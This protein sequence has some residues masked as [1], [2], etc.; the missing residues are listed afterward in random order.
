M[1]TSKQGMDFIKEME[2]CKLFAYR[3]SV[4]VVTI[5]I[6][7]TKD[8][9][10]GMAIT[11]Q[12]AEAFLAEDLKSV[13]RTLNN[14]GVNFTQAQFDALASWVFNL[15]SD[16]FDGSTLKKKILARASDEEICDQII[17][18]TRAGGKVLL[19]LQKRRIREANMFYGK[20][21]YYLDKFN[22]IMKK[23]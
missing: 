18:W 6:G 7:H 13:E 14:C 4:G 5:G 1:K 2:G 8:V 20:D 9:K 3:D 22:N 21:V 23:I 12:Q 19:G 16:A 10:M 17:R 11:Q 15:G